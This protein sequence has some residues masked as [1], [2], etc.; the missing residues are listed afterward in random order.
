MSFSFQHGMLAA[1]GVAAAVVPI[2]IHLLLRQKPRLVPFPAI[3]L[4]RNRRSLVVRSLQL[5]HLLLL[6][7][8]IAALA[9]LGFAL[10]RPMLK[11]GGPLAVDAAAPVAAMLIF[12][13]SPS[14]EYRFEGKT[15][16]EA[17]KELGREV[18]TKLGEKSEIVVIDSSTPTTHTPVDFSAAVA[19]ID[20]LVIQPAQRPIGQSIEAALRSLAKST[21]GRCEVY[22]FSDM[23]AHSWSAADAS[24]LKNAY[25]MIDGGAAI[26]VLDVAP[27]VVRNVAVSPPKLADQIVPDGGTLGIDFAIANVGPEV[28]TAL[29]ATLDG[30]VVEQRSAVL[31]ADKVTEFRF[32]LPI[33]TG[34]PHSGSIR[35]RAGDPLPFDD[36]RYFSVEARPAAKVLVAAPTTAEAEHWVNALDPAFLRGKVKPRFAV[37]LTTALDKLPESDFNKYAAVCLLDVGGV[38]APLWEKLRRYTEAGGG[39]FVALGPKTD[40]QSYNLVVAQTLLPVRL[41]GETT[42]PQAV[43][44]SLD[45]TTHPLLEPFVRLQR[46]DFGQGYVVRYWKTDVNNGATAVLRYTDGAPALV[47]RA[48]GG[49]SGKCVVLTTAAHYQPQGYWSEL[50]L[51]WSYLLLAEQIVR[52]LAGVGDA[53]FNFGVG[54]TPV[55]EFPGDGVLP[56]LA[57]VDPQ[58][59]VFKVASDPK[60]GRA[61]RLPIAKHPGIYHVDSTEEPKLAAIYAV[62]VP[63]AE[64]A[65]DPVDANRIEDL[66]EKGRVSVVKDLDSMERAVSKDRVGREL[67]G[68]IMLLLLVVVSV[69]GWV[70]SRFYKPAPGE[71]SAWGA[72]KPEAT[73]A[74]DAR[75][76]TPAATRERQEAGAV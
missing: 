63:G 24:A 52:R 17:A 33:R 61:A 35:V 18:L 48:V 34:G 4:L 14:M 16:L 76:G 46:N 20:R 60:A 56:T 6:A 7:L 23:A 51:R 21:M 30:E 32:D 45:K 2:L 59:E 49:G 57:V 55:I 75:N 25:G 73:A 42:P 8:R 22:V 39:V 58:K 38:A 3:R 10:A 74:L 68:F 44:V 26:Y 31:P 1:L 72:P 70:A 69:E 62:N 41:V 66:F 64:S 29:E 65:M 9:C 28:E 13:T 5:K 36:E 12:D 27:T 47:E 50:P 37:D 43:T 40:A 54:S 19:R 53:Q 15:R 67:F 11:M 71:A